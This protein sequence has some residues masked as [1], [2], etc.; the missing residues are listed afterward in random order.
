M[1]VEYIVFLQQIQF[2]TDTHFRL[3]KVRLTHNVTGGGIPLIY[4]RRSG[5]MTYEQLFGAPERVSGGKRIF[6]EEVR[7][8]ALPGDRSL[9]SVSPIPKVGRAKK[10]TKGGTI[11]C[12]D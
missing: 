12:D 5:I 8:Y 4:H 10:L 3:P 11:I 9:L 6:R 2:S 7:E 1:P